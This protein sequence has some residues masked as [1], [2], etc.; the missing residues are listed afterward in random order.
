[1]D[2]HPVKKKNEAWEWIK[3]LAIAI[4]LAFLIRSF[5]FAPFVVDG[6][7]MMPNLH[8]HERLIVTKL[9]YYL[10]Q[11][12]HSEII[13]FHATKDRDYIKRVIAVGGEKVQVKNDTLYI[14]DKPTE[15]PYLKEYR[16]QAHQVGVPLTDNF[17]PLVVPKN[18]LFVMGDNRR[19]SRDSRAIGTISLD[20]VVGRADVIFWPLS[21]FRFPNKSV[22]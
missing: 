18:E 12:Q 4:I 3:A 20:R 16:E 19:N 6:T 11:P 7:S 8:D 9:I 15:E 17:G 21:Q 10:E 1:L 13:V 14:N 5:L 22:K 2:E